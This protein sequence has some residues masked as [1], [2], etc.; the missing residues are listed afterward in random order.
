VIGKHLSPVLVLAWL[1]VKALVLINFQL[2]FGQVT[3]HSV[4]GQT[5]SACSQPPIS[6]Q[7][8]TLCGMV[9]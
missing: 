7:P 5:I 1:S 8:S 9:A 6:T 4:G 2:V 3:R